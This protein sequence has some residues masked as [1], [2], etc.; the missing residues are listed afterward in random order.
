MGPDGTCIGG[1]QAGGTSSAGGGGTSSAGG[2]AYL[3]NQS[4]DVAAGDLTPALG[5][6]GADT[7]GVP[8]ALV[9]ATVGIVA[10]VTGVGEVGAMVAGGGT[11]ADAAAAVGAREC[12]GGEWF[13]YDRD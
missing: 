3:S 13:L 4:G 10:T 5:M 12:G 7:S 8:S 2:V 1:V 9:G 11:V 6:S